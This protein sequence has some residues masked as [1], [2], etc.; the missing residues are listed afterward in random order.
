MN[1]E[2]LHKDITEKIIGAAMEVHR[3]LGAGFLEAV[4]SEALAYEL[5]QNGLKYEREK[6]LQ[7]QYKGNTLNKSYRADY[8]IESCVIVENKSADG[9]T[10]EAEAQV[11]NYLKATGI[12]VGLLFNFGK[13]SLEW[14]RIIWD[15]YKKSV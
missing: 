7:I 11:F 5:K 2:L 12:K 10:K 8:V 6:E 9:L 15:N 4:Y 14:K 13:P 3:T 1:T